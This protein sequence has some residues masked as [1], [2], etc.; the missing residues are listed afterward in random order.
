MKRQRIRLHGSD[1]AALRELAKTASWLE[2]GGRAAGWQ[3]Q[4]VPRGFKTQREMNEQGLGRTHWIG[5]PDWAKGWGMNRAQIRATLE[6]A[7]AGKPLG[8][9]Q[10]RLIKSMLQEHGEIYGSRTEPC[11]F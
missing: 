3:G 7:I 6:K 2:I 11:P 8:S 9:K 1:F 4:V 5:M 10:I